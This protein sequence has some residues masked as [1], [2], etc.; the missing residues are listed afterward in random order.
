MAAR[1][2]TSPKRPRKAKP[3]EPQ[4]TPCRGTGWVT[5]S[6]HVGRSQTPVGE[7][8][9]LC[10]RCLGSGIDPTPDRW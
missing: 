7:T 5:E 9:A 3:A 8:D 2:T 6:Y 1:K 10:S 4:C